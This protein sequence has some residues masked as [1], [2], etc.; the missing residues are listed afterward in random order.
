MLGNKQWKGWKLPSIPNPRPS[1][2]CNIIFKM[3]VTDVIAILSLH[4][5]YKQMS[6]TDFSENWHIGKIFYF[7]TD[8]S[9]FRNMHYQ[10]APQHALKVW[11]WLIKAAGRSCATDRQTDYRKLPPLTRIMPTIPFVNFSY[12]FPAFGQGL[13]MGVFRSELADHD[14]CSLGWSSTCPPMD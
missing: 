3:Q 10:Y 12:Q 14:H 4:Y 5:F 6:G 1:L 11:A 8:Q 2:H 9:D 7:L 13:I